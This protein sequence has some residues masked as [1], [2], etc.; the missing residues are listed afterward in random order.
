MEDTRAIMLG[1]RLKEPNYQVQKKILSKMIPTKRLS[2]SQLVGQNPKQ[3]DYFPRIWN[4]QCRT[5][6][7]QAVSSV[8]EP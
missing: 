8:K 7:L 1:Q 2:N 4:S 3:G 5:E 6:K